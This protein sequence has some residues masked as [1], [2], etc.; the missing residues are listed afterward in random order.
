MHTYNAAINSAHSIDM[1]VK[2]SILSC[3]SYSTWYVNISVPTGTSDTY[4]KELKFNIFIVYCSIP[5][6]EETTLTTHYINSL[7]NSS[8]FIFRS[9][10]YKQVTLKLISVDKESICFKV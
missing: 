2:M 1:L 7:L 5:E 9:F 10:E 4:K 8:G 3:Y 6:A